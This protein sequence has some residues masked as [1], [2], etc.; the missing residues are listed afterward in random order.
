[1]LEALKPFNSDRLFMASRDRDDFPHQA[2]PR[3][4]PRRVRQHPL[5]AYPDPGE[6]R[7]PQGRRYRL[8][9]VPQ[10][11]ISATLGEIRC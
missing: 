3:V 5:T 9:P 4:Q 10:L 7:R 8:S 11:L 1:M 6:D 2:R